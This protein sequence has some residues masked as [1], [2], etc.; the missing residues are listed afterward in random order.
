FNTPKY[1]TN[2]TLGNSNLFKGLG[3]NLAWHWQSAFDWYGTFN[4]MEPGRINAYSLVDLQF[5]KKIYKLH[6]TFKLGSSNLFNNKVYQ[7]YGSPAI[8]AI[9]YVGFTFDGLLK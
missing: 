2:V 1:S 5:S 7:A 8:G 6:T 4:G 3:F 9:Y